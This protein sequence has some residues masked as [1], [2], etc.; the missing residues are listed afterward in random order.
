MMLTIVVSIPTQ[1]PADFPRESSGDNKTG[2]YRH[3][4]EDYGDTSPVQF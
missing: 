1:L 4:T 2:R 3:I